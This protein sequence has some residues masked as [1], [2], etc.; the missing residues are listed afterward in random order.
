MASPT[1]AMCFTSS[2]MMLPGQPLPGG[3]L[4]LPSDWILCATPTGSAPACCAN[5][6]S[7]PSPPRH[8][9]C[10]NLCCDILPQHCPSMQSQLASTFRSLFLSRLTVY[11]TMT[12][13]MATV[14]DLVHSNGGG[15]VFGRKSCRQLSPLGDRQSCR[16]V[17]NQ[18]TAKKKEAPV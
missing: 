5:L 16:L 18:E 11:R 6:V 2:H 1:L 8:Y 10:C 14:E 12:G 17:Q 7:A 15:L 4:G 13:Y 9:F 3:D